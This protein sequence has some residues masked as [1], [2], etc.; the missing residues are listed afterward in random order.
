MHLIDY[1]VGDNTFIIGNCHDGGV[2]LG[3]PIRIP[4]VSGFSCGRNNGISGFTA[5]VAG[6]S[7]VSSSGVV[8]S[9]PPQAAKASAANANTSTNASFFSY[10]SSKN[11]DFYY[12]FHTSLL[13]AGRI[14]LNNV[15]VT[16][17]AITPETS[18]IGK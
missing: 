15:D 18:N 5:P 3:K 6:A 8:A 9:P 11:K 7:E 10:S 13:K 2:N 1:T 16:I 14:N 12:L 4:S 17:P